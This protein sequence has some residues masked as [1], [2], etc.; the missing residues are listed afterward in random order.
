MTT[1]C[2]PTAR[3]ALRV[4]RGAALVEFALTFPL[5]VT[6]IFASIEVARVN[7]LRHML[8][9]AAYQGAR[10]GTVPG[11]TAAQMTATAQ[12]MLASVSAQGYTITV[13]PAAITS[14]TTAVTVS[15][16]LPLSGNGWVAPLFFKGKTLTNTCTLQRDVFEVSTVP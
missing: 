10:T 6:F 16:S 8:A 3:R 13:S 14:Q 9:D 7:M 1:R 15:I 11:S 12:T 2:R 5:L 4:R